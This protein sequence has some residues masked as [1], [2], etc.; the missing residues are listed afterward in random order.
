MEEYHKVRK[1]KSR[2][3]FGEVISSK[4][5]GKV[6]NGTCKWKFGIVVEKYP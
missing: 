4:T 1:G 3:G 5:E 2:M 6:D